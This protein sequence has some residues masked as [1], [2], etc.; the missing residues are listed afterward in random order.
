[1]TGIETALPPT[2]KERALACALGELAFEIEEQRHR[3]LEIAKGRRRRE[4]IEI[5]KTAYFG[6]IPSRLEHVL[7]SIETDF[8]DGATPPEQIHCRVFDPTVLD[9]ARKVI[10]AYAASIGAKS[11]ELIPAYRH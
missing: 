5:S 7:F 2:A 4:I 3:T 8:V 6:V 1:M 9:L 10:G 11:V